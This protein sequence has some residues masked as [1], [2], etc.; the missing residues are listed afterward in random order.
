MSLGK[1]VRVGYADCIANV[2]ILRGANVVVASLLMKRHL[3]GFDAI[4]SLI[5]QRIPPF[6]A[7]VLWC[8]VV[9]VV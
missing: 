2:A 1:G 7:F 5:V 3:L 9:T 4:E 6:S 8:V